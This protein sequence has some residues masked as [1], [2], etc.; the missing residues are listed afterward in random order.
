MSLIGFYI[1]VDLRGG[2]IQGIFSSL[3]TT[4]HDDPLLIDTC[5]QKF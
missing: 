2:N 4:V 5:Q 3:D 1:Y